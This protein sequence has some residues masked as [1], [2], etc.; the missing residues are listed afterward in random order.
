ME[1][2]KYYTEEDK[3]L[4]ETILPDNPCV[5]CGMGI[6]C[7]VC[8]K[9]REYDKTII[10]YKNAGV[11]ETALK[12]KSIVNIKNKI[13]DLVNEYNSISQELPFFLCNSTIEIINKLK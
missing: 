4:L 6:A 1:Y 10:P 5:S 3:K 13:K 8:S 12:L 9:G 7:C 11:Y 2:I